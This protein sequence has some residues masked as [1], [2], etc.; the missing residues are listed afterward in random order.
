MMKIVLQ[1]KS[2]DSRGETMG[3]FDK[4]KNLFTEEVEEVEEV[5]PKS[6][7]RETRSVDTP[8]FRRD[9]QVKRETPVFRDEEIEKPKVEE[10]KEKFVFPVYFDDKDFDDLEKPK[11]KEKVE[12]KPKPKVEP[13]KGAKASI[14]PEPKKVFKPSPIISPV[15]GVLDKN[16]R[17]DDITTKQDS[18]RHTS[19]YKKEHLTIDDIRNKAYGT[20]E[21]DLEGSLTKEIEVEPKLEDNKDALDMFNDLDF[22]SMSQS[23]D[24]FESLEKKVLLDSNYDDDTSSLTKQLEEQRKKLDEINHYMDENEISL[25]D[26]HRDHTVIDSKIDDTDLKDDDIVDSENIK[27][28]E[29]LDKKDVNSAPL[30]DKKDNATNLNDSELFDLIDSMYEKRDDE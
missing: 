6:V 14:T 9:T 12:E 29:S 19:S 4:V 28:D 7:K 11:P 8:V 20:L 13:Y 25:K 18:V 10:P 30:E 16:Y 5:A 22:D 24:S 27:K 23:K 2:K 21:D 3:F 15:Y 26:E 17:K 1:V